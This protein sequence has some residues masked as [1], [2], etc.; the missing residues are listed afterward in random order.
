YP[1]S[2]KRRAQSFVRQERLPVECGYSA[3]RPAISIAAQVGMRRFPKAQEATREAESR[4]DVDV[5]VP[6]GDV[7]G[8]RTIDAPNL[9]L[10]VLTLLEPKE[11]PELIAT[12]SNKANRSI[13]K[14]LLDHFRRAGKSLHHRVRGICFDDRETSTLFLRG[15]CGETDWLGDKVI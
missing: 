4:F 10:T 2:E 1:A 5:V 9:V 11:P 7:A 12:Q 15:H 6:H 8:K 3:H 14:A 13:T